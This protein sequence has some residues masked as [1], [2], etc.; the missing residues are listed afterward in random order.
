MGEEIPMRPQRYENATAVTVLPRGS[1]C[2]PWLSPLQTA[3]THLLHAERSATPHQQ[4]QAAIFSC[5]RSIVFP[6][7]FNYFA[8][9]LQRTNMITEDIC[10]AGCK[11]L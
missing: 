10:P 5:A 4:T 8:V 11:E 1:R 6:N 9:N 7:S 3:W 2:G